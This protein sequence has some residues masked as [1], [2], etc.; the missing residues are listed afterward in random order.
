MKPLEEIIMANTRIFERHI[1]YIALIQ[2]REKIIL[3]LPCPLH[4]ELKRMTR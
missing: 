2:I 4:M 1:R 3:N